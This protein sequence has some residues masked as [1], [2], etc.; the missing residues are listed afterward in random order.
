M[1][2]SAVRQ[3]LA[4]YRGDIKMGEAQLYFLSDQYYVDFP[5]DKLM[6]NKEIVAGQIS[7]RPCFLAFAD[8]AVPK[9]FWLVPISSRV[10]K[11][12]REEQKK[13]ERY[14][15]CNTIR[16]GTVL[17]R[18]AAFLIQNM[19]PVTGRYMTPYV[20]K[21]KRPI[22]LDGRVV[23][24]V[25]RNAHEVLGIANRGARVIFPDIKAIYAALVLQLQGEEK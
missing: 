23:A 2:G 25:V 20:D 11:Y 14:G 24:D 18:E 7:R 13:I 10:E 15:R 22:R 4:F 12:R 3:S 21:N 9:I 17:G 6:R 16:F 8:K 5:D 1:R 19:C